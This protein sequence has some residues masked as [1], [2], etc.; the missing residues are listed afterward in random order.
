MARWALQTPTI[1]GRTTRMSRTH[2]PR[3]ALNDIKH[4]IDEFILGAFS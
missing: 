3:R 2:A 1:M 4:A